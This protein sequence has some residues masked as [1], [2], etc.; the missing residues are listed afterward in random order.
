LSSKG[1]A[2]FSCL[3]RGSTPSKR[4]KNLKIGGSKKQPAEL[5]EGQRAPPRAFQQHKHSA[6]RLFSKFYT[7]ND[8]PKNQAARSGN[9]PNPVAGIYCSETPPPL[10]VQIQNH[11]HPDLCETK[12]TNAHKVCNRNQ[13]KS[14]S[15]WSPVE[16]G[17]SD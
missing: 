6:S 8:Q 12:P 17:R 14:S 16:R 11:V 2:K 13:G 4:A 10:P 9:E 1:G 15:I 7:E 5:G 3:E